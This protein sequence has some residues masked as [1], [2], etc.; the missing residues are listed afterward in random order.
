M[1]YAKVIIDISHESVDRAFEYIIPEALLNEVNPGSAVMVPFGKG[2]R[3]RQ[4]YVIEIEDTPCYD[5]D[6]LKEIAGICEKAETV[7]KEAIDLAL[8]MS[9]RYGSTLIN[10]LKTTLPVKEKVSPKIKKVVIRK[11]SEEEGQELLRTFLSKSHFAK[12]RIME[13]LLSDEVI[14]YELLTTKLHVSP[15]AVKSLESAGYLETD[16]KQVFRNKKSREVCAESVSLSDEQKKIAYEIIEG[17][18]KGENVNSLIYGITGSGKTEVY[19]KIAEDLISMGKQVIMLIPE[20]ALTYQT[21]MRFYNRFGD[22]VC[23]INSRMSKGEK[24]DQYVRAREGLI[25]IVIGPRSALFTPFQNLGAIII[26]EEHERS[27]KSEGTPRFHAREVAFKKAEMNGAFVVLGSATPSL[28]AYKMAMEGDIR[29]YKLTRRLTGGK[30]P[31]VS[32]VD[33]RKELREGNRSI[34]SRELAEK[35]VD[36]LNRK[37]QSMLFINRRGI[38]GFVSCR[39]C[40]K[41]MKCPHCDVSLSQH[42]SGKLICHYCGYET[43]MP[44]LC[45]CCG[46]KYILGFKAGTERIEDELLRLFP[47]I[48][49]LRMD[50][51]TTKT[52]DS[53]DEIL[54]AFANQEA[55][56]LVG[57]Q[58]IVKGHDFRNVTLVGIVA[59][60]ISLFSGDYRSAETTFDLLTQAAGRAGRG[61]K[62]GEVVIQTYDP[63][64]Y[65]IKWAS[66]QDYDSF[67]EEE[68][69][70][71]EFMMYPP[72]AH[73]LAVHV[74]GSDV[75]CAEKRANIIKAETADLTGEDVF[76]IGPAPLGISKI[77]DI[78]RFVLYYKS[79][80]YDKLIEVKDRIEKSL[81]DKDDNNEVYFDF[82]P[83]NTQM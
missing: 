24:Y 50:A 75:S 72:M 12:A 2:N 83:M 46:S 29:L 30:L 51:D 76:V 44:A 69:M 58:M 35:L 27:Y 15:A 14:P 41:V 37:E 66:L 54:A 62:G 7:S 36:R 49:V 64:N 4:G 55:D 31:Y 45:P 56:V 71:R 79:V 19:L 78:Y 1:K 22:R 65:A 25:D 8:W 40:G 59:A 42:R 6:K 5:A 9:R 43:K 73:M 3:Q 57:T 60:D 47:G 53:Y 38:A 80:S 67:Y 28:E 16:S 63:E 82:D 34:F 77:K 74:Q 61:D 11:C 23:A 10:S 26:D 70:Y 39:S 32:I 20:I 81:K 48:K 68:K 21:L 52:K 33:L 13:A 18:R 17:Y